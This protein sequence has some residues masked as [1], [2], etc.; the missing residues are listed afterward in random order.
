MAS[1]FAQRRWREQESRCCN[2][3]P[4]K[5]PASVEGPSERICVRLSFESG[6]REHLDSLV[7]AQRDRHHHTHKMMER[8]L[9]R[10]RALVIGGSVGGLFAAHLLRDIG[11]NVTV[12]ER[13]AGDLG[14]RGTGIGTREELFA[15][16]RRIGLATGA[17]VGIDVDGRVGLDRDGDVI[18]ELP[19]R[20][21]TSAWSSI[22]RPLRQAWPDECYAGGK[23]LVGIEQSEK[24]VGAVFGDGSRFDGDLLVGTDGLRSTV[25][26]QFLPELA[27][28][29]AGYVAWRGVVEAAAL[30]PDLGALMLHRMVFGFPDGEL[31]LSIPMPALRG[32]ERRACHFVWFRPVAEA[33]VTDLCTDA[34][35]KRHG[36]SIPPPLIRP[37]LI[38][39]VKQDAAA[40]LAPQLAAL[41][42]AT[43]QTIL[44]PIFE[45]ASPRVTFG[46]VALAGDAAFVA[47]PHV[48]TGVM[49][50]AIDAE[51]LAGVLTPNGHD[52]TAALERYN[53]ERQP[54]GAALVARGRHIGEYLVDRGGDRQQRIETLM[55]EYGAAGLVQDQAIRARLPH[56]PR[57][58][59]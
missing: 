37:E 46:R 30:S 17:S 56:L 16:M 1:V 51:S 44:Q 6:R 41:V 2:A 10:R 47:R 43:A 45:L 31:M 21:V 4:S 11:W 52:V 5:K 36:V 26:A 55:R 39:A 14:D 25:R 24:H 38:A 53:A 19:I 29:Y 34:N 9:T 18:R 23:I 20:A 59:V 35:G 15:V 28:C 42:H 49:K 48:A 8:I 12:F 33:A 54:Y 50:A 40:L 32:K 58:A 3:K 7:G 13:A 57:P 27:P 22:W